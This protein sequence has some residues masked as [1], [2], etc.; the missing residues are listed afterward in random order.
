MA[1][2][3]LPQSGIYPGINHLMAGSGVKLNLND[4]ATFSSTGIGLGAVHHAEYPVMD[5]EPHRCNIH[6]A[7]M[8]R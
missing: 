5:S 6:V 2:G 4:K 3:L 1:F 8:C 7:V